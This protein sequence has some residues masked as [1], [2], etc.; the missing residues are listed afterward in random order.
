MA[1]FTLQSCTMLHGKFVSD[2]SESEEMGMTGLKQRLIPNCPVDANHM[3]MDQRKTLY[4]IRALK[5]GAYVGLSKS[6]ESGRPISFYFLNDSRS[7]NVKWVL[8]QDPTF[9]D[10]LLE[11]YRVDAVDW[12]SQFSESSG[13][14]I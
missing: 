13:K 4:T 7:N 10:R 5:P 1:R 9:P 14:R 8:D 6:K 2:E 3:D 12:G 11:V